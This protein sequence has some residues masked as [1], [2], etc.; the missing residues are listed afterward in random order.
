MTK[1]QIYRSVHSSKGSSDVQEHTGACQAFSGIRTIAVYI[2]S[3]LP[4]YW[5]S[6]IARA[7]SASLP[8]EVQ[9]EYRW[10]NS[11]LGVLWR[12]DDRFL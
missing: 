3:K 9:V 1:P 5:I 10:P 7:V 6:I 11:E 4:V 2:Y 8:N 12:K